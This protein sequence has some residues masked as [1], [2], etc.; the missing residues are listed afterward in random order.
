MGKWVGKV[1]PSC[2]LWSI[3]KKYPSSDGSYIPFKGGCEDKAR[4]FYGD[5]WCTLRGLNFRDLL[6]LGANYKGLPKLCWWHKI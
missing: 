1:I 4:Q 3:H 6:D 2:A 5:N